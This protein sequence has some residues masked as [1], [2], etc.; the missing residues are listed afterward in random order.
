MKGTRVHST[1]F[2]VIS[3]EALIISKLKVK[4]KEEKKTTLEFT[5]GVGGLYAIKRLWLTPGLE[6]HNVS[7]NL[8][9]FR[10]GE[11]SRLRCDVHGKHGLL[12]TVPKK[13]EQEPCEMGHTGEHQGQSRGRWSTRTP[14]T[15][16]FTVVLVGRKGWDGVSS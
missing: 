6:F 7:R 13:R 11:S 1:H 3:C 2:F 10:Y 5:R 4:R 9:V 12:L 16:A 8:F 14:W 15:G